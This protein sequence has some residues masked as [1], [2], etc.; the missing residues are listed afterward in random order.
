MEIS[1]KNRILNIEL[2]IFWQPNLK[3]LTNELQL[4]FNQNEIEGM[5]IK[6]F[7]LEKVWSNYEI[8]PE[9]PYFEERL[10]GGDYS[11]KIKEIGR[12]YGVRDLG[13]VGFCYHK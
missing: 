5:Q 7:K 6:K 8:M 9:E 11:N 3:K 1:L 2:N 13:F 12:K 10:S 4:F